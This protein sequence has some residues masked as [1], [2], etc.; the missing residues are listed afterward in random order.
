ML[1]TLRH[2]GR[3]RLETLGWAT[4]TQLDRRY[5]V[6]LAEAASAG[7]TGADPGTW[8]KAIDRHL[9][10]LRAAHNWSVQHEPDLAMRLAAA[11]YWYVEA[12]SSSEVALWAE[13][14][15][16]V[17]GPSHPLLPLVLAVAGWGAVNEVTFRCHRIRPPRARRQRRSQD[18]RR[19]PAHGAAMSD[20]DAVICA[21]TEIARCTHSP[22]LEPQY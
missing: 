13:R 10:D 9:D 17:A 18:Y 12:G 14:S 2:Y 7:L 3:E 11:L 22:P 15:A 21:A 19:C 5:H 6:E 8:S 4:S 16:A 1:D 20:D